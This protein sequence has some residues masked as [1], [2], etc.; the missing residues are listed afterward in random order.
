MSKAY[1][2]V[3]ERDNSTQEDAPPDRNATVTQEG[4][5]I[6]LRIQNFQAADVSGKI[7]LQRDTIGRHLMAKRDRFKHFRCTPF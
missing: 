5:A 7:N 3:L 1:Q 6:Q 2:I 4:N